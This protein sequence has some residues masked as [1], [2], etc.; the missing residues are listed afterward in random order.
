MAKTNVV[1]ELSIQEVNTA[2]TEAA[3]KACKDCGGGGSTVE[4]FKDNDGGVLG[5]RVSFS[6]S[7]NP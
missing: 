3:R 6:W 7:R 2:L 1:V 4:I 5:A